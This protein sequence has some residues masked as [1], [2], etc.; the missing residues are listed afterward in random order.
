MYVPL[1]LLIKHEL[2]IVNIIFILM[3][4]LLLQYLDLPIMFL[5][6]LVPI[7]ILKE[8]SYHNHLVLHCLISLQGLIAVNLW[9]AFTHPDHHSILLWK[10]K[11]VLF[12]WIHHKLCFLPWCRDCRD[13]MLLFFYLLTVSHTFIILID[14]TTK[15]LVLI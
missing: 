12:P 11:I 5:Q 2:T 8:D 14:L 1:T 6:L 15:I 3:F 9:H 4:I 7:L 10:V 13:T